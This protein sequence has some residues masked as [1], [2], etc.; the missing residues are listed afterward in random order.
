MTTMTTTETIENRAREARNAATRSGGRGLFTGYR[1]ILEALATEQDGVQ[2]IEAIALESDTASEVSHFAQ[3]ALAENPETSA[4]TL[5]RVVSVITDSRYRL[6]AG[7]MVAHI[8]Y[9]HANIG[10]EA[11]TALARR[12]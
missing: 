9:G 5:N 1:D 8:I 2:V 6:E 10:A 11:R 12:F 3:I 4:E 7:E